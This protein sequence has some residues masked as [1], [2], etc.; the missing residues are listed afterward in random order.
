MESWHH[1]IF[2]LDNGIFFGTNL[3]FRAHY[4]SQWKTCRVKYEDN[5]EDIIH[6]ISL[7][8]VQMRLPFF[9]MSVIYGSILYH[10]RSHSVRRLSIHSGVFAVRQQRNRR[11]TKLFLT[12]VIVFFVLTLPFSIFYIWYTTNRGKLSPKNTTI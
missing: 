4:A 5:K 6:T 9:I 10:L 11:P 1:S 7:F 8:L 2:Y 12:V 3:F